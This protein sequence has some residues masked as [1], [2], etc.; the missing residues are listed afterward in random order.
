MLDTQTKLTTFVLGLFIST[1]TVTIEEQS[2]QYN[3]V[4]YRSAIAPHDGVEVQIREAYFPPGW[5]APRHYHN[6]NLFIYVIEGDFEVELEGSEKITYS[7]GD[8]LQMNSGI[9][10]EAR[11]ANA[12]NPLKLSV[13]QVGNPDSPFVVPV[14]VTK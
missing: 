7:A 6:S 14:N 13:F 10:M 1:S 9:E 12:V 4:L 8:A 11:N 5:I 2:T 3:K